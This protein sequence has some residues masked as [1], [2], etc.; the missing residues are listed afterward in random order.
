VSA[1]DCARTTVGRGRETTGRCVEEVIG[2]SLREGMR[3]TKL[4]RLREGYYS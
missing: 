1:G 3:Y 4:Q 2:A